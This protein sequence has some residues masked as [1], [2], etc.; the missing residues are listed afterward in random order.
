MSERRVQQRV[1]GTVV[2]MAIAVA[3]AVLLRGPLLRVVA[4]ISRPFAAAGTFVTN[5][6]AG[7]CENV[8]FVGPDRVSELT[9]QRNAL[10]IDGSE[11]ERLREENQQLREQL[12]FITRRNF[13]S[14]SASVISRSFALRSLSFVID[15]GANDGIVVGSPVIVGDGILVGKVLSV[16]AS[17]AKIT[18]STDPEMA[19]AA[20]LLNQTRTLGLAQGMT[21]TL[22]A[23]KYIPNDERVAVNDLVVTSGLE[24]HMPSGLMIGIVNAVHSDPSAPFQEAIVEPPIDVRRFESVT[25]ILDNLPV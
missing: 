5:Q 23:L 19:T 11:L 22:L 14:V 1:I 6:A 21:S 3:I 20:T 17:T 2:A 18:A 25:V 12:A 13:R 4:A 7:F 9:A 24:E 10:A 16:T 8:A 15:R